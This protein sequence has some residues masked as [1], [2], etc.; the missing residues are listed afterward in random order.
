MDFVVMDSAQR[1][2]KLIADLQREASW[3]GVAHVVSVR[4]RASTDDTW[5]TRDV[6]EVRLA[7]DP[8]RLADRQRALV[9]LWQRSAVAQLGR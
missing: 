2:C 8:P 5:L 1:N 3:L 9:N 7:P 6:A 4:W